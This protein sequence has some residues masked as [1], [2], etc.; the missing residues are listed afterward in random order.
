ML[1]HSGHDYCTHKDEQRISSYSK[2]TALTLRGFSV[3]QS[4]TRVTKF[5]TN[6]ATRFEHFNEMPRIFSSRSKQKSG[7]KFR[8]KRIKTS[9]I[10]WMSCQVTHSRHPPAGLFYLPLTTVSASLDCCWSA[11]CFEIRPPGWRRPRNPCSPAYTNEERTMRKK[12]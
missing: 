6:F 11:D 12:T 5:Q 10:C 2:T 7:V 9:L 8:F 1:V 3:T 4:K